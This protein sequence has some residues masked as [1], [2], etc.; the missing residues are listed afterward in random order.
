M[1]ILATCQYCGRDFQLDQL[2]EG[3]VITGKCPWCEE[4]LAPNYTALLPEVIRRAET[5]KSE[6]GSALRMLSGSWVGFRIKP[7]SVLEPLQEVLGVTQEQERGRARLRDRLREA[8]R[9]AEQLSPTSLSQRWPGEADEIVGLE[10]E[11]RQAGVSA[12]A[13]DQRA[14]QEVASTSTDLAGTADQSG[15]S[16]DDVRKEVARLSE[17]GGG[18]PDALARLAAATEELSQAR[19]AVEDSGANEEKVGA[20]LGRLRA[21][22]REA[23]EALNDPVA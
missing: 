18:R 22:L 12:E 1:K 9:S 13:V 7:E 8:V 6:L 10:R 11:L 17:A 3:P 23:E 20:A 15:A 19:K 21:A 5:G 14:A 16:G 2:I 4:L